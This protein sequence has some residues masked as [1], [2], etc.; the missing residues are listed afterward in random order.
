MSESSRLPERW[1]HTRR[2]YRLNEKRTNRSDQ[3]MKN[4]KT[5]KA[6]HDK[7]LAQ[8]LAKETVSQADSKHAVAQLEAEEC[9]KAEL[10]ERDRIA[11]ERLERWEEDQ[12]EL[13]RIEAEEHVMQA[14]KLQKSCRAERG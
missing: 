9:K 2:W 8:Q 14:R 3:R 1:R 4:S 6:Q 7:L 11:Q 10:H 5:L 13:K 12:K